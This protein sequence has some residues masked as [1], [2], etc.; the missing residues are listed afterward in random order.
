MGSADDQDVGERIAEVREDGLLAW[1]GSGE[2]V[3][4]L[5][6]F[7]AGALLTLATPNG[8][9]EITGVI[10][11]RPSL[12]KV[13]STQQRW[14]LAMFKKRESIERRLPA[15]WESLGETITADGAAS[16]AALKRVEALEQEATAYNDMAS[17][18]C[19]PL[20]RVELPDWA[21]E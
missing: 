16:V 10:L 1:R 4:G 21:Q 13:T 5:V 15:A 18:L 2:L 12:P 19:L 8:H 20:L 11:Q 9:H 3:A 17:E 6:G 7:P 14:R